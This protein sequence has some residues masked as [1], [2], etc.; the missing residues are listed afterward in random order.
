MP[1]QKTE[2]VQIQTLPSDIQPDIAKVRTN[3]LLQPMSIFDRLRHFPNDV[4]DLSAESRM[5]KFLKVLLGDAGAGQLRKHIL[6]QRLQSTLQGSHFYNLDR[7]YGPLFGLK[8]S[9]D[10]LLAFDPYVSTASKDQW[11]IAHAKDAS[12]R[13]RIEQFSR[14]LLY[15][16]TPTGMELI[17]EALLAVDVDVFESWIQADASYQ[18]YQEL[19]DQYGSPLNSENS[20]SIEDDDTA[21]QIDSNVSDLSRST[22][23]FFPQGTEP[24][25]G[26]ASLRITCDGVG[27]AEVSIVETLNATPEVEYTFAGVT[28]FFGYLDSLG[29]PG[30][31][32]LESGESLSDFLRVRLRID[33]YNNTPTLISTVRGDSVW[34]DD[35]AQQVFVTAEAPANADTAVVIIEVVEPVATDEVFFDR[36]EW[37]SLNYGDMDGILYTD[38]EGLGLARLSGDERRTFTI[39]PKRPITLSESYDLGK[40]LHKTKPADTRFLIDAQGVNLYDPVEIVGAYSDSEFWEVVPKVASASFTNE[41]YPIVSGSPQEQPSPPFSGYQGEAWSYAT[42]LAGVAAY[43]RTSVDDQPAV[44]P[45]TRVVYDNDKIAEFNPEQAML[46]SRMVYAGRIVSDAIAVSWPFTSHRSRNRERD[47]SERPLYVD[48]IPVKDFLSTL[49]EIPD[50]DPFQQNLANRYF[51]TQTKY[52]NDITEEILEIRMN[53]DSWVNYITFEAVKY[54]HRVIVE[55]YDTEGA[56]WIETLRWDYSSSI[57]SVLSAGRSTASREGH[58]HH[59]YENHWERIRH[60]L[61]TPQL[62]SRIRLRMRRTEGEAPLASKRHRERRVPYSLAIRGFDVGYRVRNRDDFN[63]IEGETIASTK[64]MFGSQL[65]FD[66]AEKKAENTLSNSTDFWRSDPQP[67]NYSVVNLY[68]DTTDEGD[69]KV[70]DRFYL[71]PTHDGAHL[72]IYYSMDPQEL[73]GDPKEFMSN[74]TWTPIPRDFTV[75]RGNIYIPPTRARYWKFEFTNLTA[76]AFENFLP[77]NREV[78]LFPRWIVDNQPTEN[79][80][81]ADEALLPGMRTAIDVADA[82]TYEDAIGTLQQTSLDV[83][84]YKPTESLYITDVNVA[85]NMNDRSWVFGFTPWHQDQSAPRFNT[86]S[87]HIYETAHVRHA[88]KVAFFVGLRELRAYR[89]NWEVKDDPSFYFDTFDDFRNLQSGF[90]WAFD[91][92]YLTSQG[93]TPPVTVE[94][95]TFSSRSPVKAIQFAT[96]QSNPIQLVPDPDFRNPSLGSY[97]WNNPDS[98]LEV[99]DAVH[100]Y[101]PQ[102]FSV[103]VI[104]YLEPPLKPLDQTSGMVQP[105]PNPVYSWRPYEV[106]DSEALAATEGGTDSPLLGLSDDGRAHAAI[107]FTMLTDQTSPLIL[108]IIDQ[109][110]DSVV[111]EKELVAQKNQVVEDYISFDIPSPALIVRMRLYQTGKSNDSWKLMSMSMFDESMI[112]EFSANGGGDWY[113]TKDIRN[114]DNGLMTFPVPGNQLKYRVTA[115]RTNQWVSAIKIRPHYTGAGNARSNGTHRGANISFYDHDVPIHVDPM[116]TAWKKPVPFYW[117]AASRRFPLLAVDGATTD[118]SFGGFYGRPATFTVGVPEITLESQVFSFRVWEENLFFS[119]PTLDIDRVIEAEREIGI[120]VDAPEIGVVWAYV[121][122]IESGGTIHPFVDPVFSESEEDDS[123]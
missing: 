11:A 96:E 70:V 71:D 1:N 45:T 54:P 57:P 83:G 119:G 46:P 69:G 56:E 121:S 32:E 105:V 66:V 118:T 87:K 73:E 49:K 48:N 42:D 81:H 116:F 64:D 82:I 98:Y 94:S 41:P 101:Q 52:Q 20:I 76:E 30:E 39:S 110:D 36:L 43:S 102:D 29:S 53:R 63:F 117:F 112:W 109:S 91:P 25:D 79:Q 50:V 123:I 3:L 93:T 34:P 65:T 115:L 89:S 18:S 58:P 122:G 60:N 51:V 31:L 113:K 97:E 2:L 22:E 111:A 80:G 23:W 4:Y 17:A 108:Q 12:F 26:E 47:D 38:L 67:I 61:P 15:G 107:R 9:A 68:L 5:V 7:F 92:G 99:G 85:R 59:N 103:R 6:M 62:T 14:A 10:E 106:E 21:W 35:L 19:E 75:Q 86:A 72:T 84:E 33:W 24:D 74:R 100:I 90:D 13:S 8:R 27:D 78:N 114:N 16:P 44:L 77:I 28:A 40:V 95:R 37:S 88:S 120:T 104:R 55:V